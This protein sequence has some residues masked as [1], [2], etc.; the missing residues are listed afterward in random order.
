MLSYCEKMA[1]EQQA[2]VREILALLER[3]P[4]ALSSVLETARAGIT[5]T[6]QLSSSPVASSSSSD[7]ESPQNI[8]RTVD[9][10]ST[11]YSAEDLLAKRGAKGKGSKAQQTFRVS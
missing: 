9:V 6:E 10:L 8:S 2:M 1:G 7:G 11:A 5:T 4:D 3:N